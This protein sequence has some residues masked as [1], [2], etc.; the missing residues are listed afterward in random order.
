MNRYARFI[1]HCTILAVD[2]EG[3][4]DQRRTIPNQLA[5]RNGLYRILRQAFDAAR[6]PWAA[7]YCEDRGDGV[8]L[9][10]PAQI[11]K[12]PFVDSLPHALI[13]G[14]RQ[15]NSVHPAEEQIRLRMVLNAGE[16]AFDQH[17]VTA[18]SINL[19]CRLLS[20][21]ALKAALADSQGVLALITSEWF[22]DD[23]VR[24]SSGTNH[25]EFRPVHVLV[26][27]TS[28]V[29]WVARPDHPYR[30]ENTRFAVLPPWNQSPAVGN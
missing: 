30:P 9:L 24:H 21:P 25:T 19:A 3:F 2:I 17:G 7:C 12:A 15:H 11:P 18:S 22:F 14:I 23:V 26:K 28:T 1:A 8:I 4:G 6:I 27:E 13:A 20:A 29:G 10:A 5:M 16:V